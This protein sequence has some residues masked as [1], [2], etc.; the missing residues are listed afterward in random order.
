MRLNFKKVIIHNFLSYAHSEI[1]LNDRGYCLVGGINNC[2]L[3][4]SKSNG[5]GKSSWSSAICFAL[6]GET[7][8]GIKTNLKNNFIEEKSCYVT[9]ILE[10]NK[11]LY[12]I[13]RYREPKPDLRIIK[14]GKDI[15]GKGI[16]E[17]NVVLAQEIPELTSELLASIV[18]LGQG[19]PYKFSNNTPSGRKE[20]LEKLAKSDFMIQDL[21]NRITKRSIDLSSSLRTIDD[22]LLVLNTRKTATEQTLTALNLKLKDF[23]NPIDFDSKIATLNKHIEVAQNLVKQRENDI[24]AKNK[25]YDDANNAYNEVSNRLNVEIHNSDSNK[26]SEVTQENNDYNDFY[27]E[28]LEKNSKLSSEITLLK[29]KILQVSQIKEVCPTCGQKLVGVVKPSTAQEEAR[30]AEL[31]KDSSKLFETY[32]KYSAEHSNTIRL[33]ESTY[34]KNNDEIKAKYKIEL[35]N[36]RIILEG[37]KK[38]LA[39]L[40]A[41]GDFNLSALQQELLKCQLA[42]QTFTT[43]LNSI[44]KDRESNTLILKNIN[45]ELLYN[46]SDKESVEKHID[47]VNKLNTIVKRDFRGFLLSNIIN[48]IDSRVKEYSKYVFGSDRLDFKLDGND[49]DISYCGKPFDNLSGGEAQKVD[50]VIQF[51]IRDMMYQYSGFSSNILILD[52]VFDNLDSVGCTNVLSL[53]SEKFNDIESMFIVSHHVDELEIPNDSEMMI[54]KDANGVSSIK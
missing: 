13:T 25:E 44:K 10:V 37:I 32:S 51:A 50:L 54:V 42:K 15:S 36:K 43:N 48:Y 26:I 2:P 11:D 22:K 8:K 33:I 5:S 35:D 14:N 28:Y 49:I 45:D 12:E 4:K 30:L 53:I 52:E 20:V 9:V 16:K 40:H 21:K 34:A 38:E 24:I 27:K 29:Q 6:T 31:Q 1:D 23:E 46:N 18:I 47:A 19:L 41:K 39:E 7:I 3:D 17:S